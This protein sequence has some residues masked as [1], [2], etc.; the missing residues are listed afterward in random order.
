MAG[1][2]FRGYGATQ[3]CFA[4]ESAA[5]ELAAHLGIDPTELRLRNIPSVGDPMPAFK[6]GPLSSSRL[7]DCIRRG[8]ELSAG[9]KNTP[10]AS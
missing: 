6:D 3:G 2:A 4:I 1:G 5:N 8:R 10:A 7:E 9:M